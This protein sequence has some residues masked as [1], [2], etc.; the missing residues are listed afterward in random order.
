[1][2]WPGLADSGAC[3]IRVDGH[4]GR[5][6]GIDIQK[7]IKGYQIKAS[8]FDGSHSGR[9]NGANQAVGKST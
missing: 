6:G 3:A 4:I 7:K 8:G 9:E 1:M 5:G 2:E